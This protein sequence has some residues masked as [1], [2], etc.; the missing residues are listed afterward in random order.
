MNS[1]MNSI[2]RDSM[3]S[4]QNLDLPAHRDPFSSPHRRSPVP[5]DD[6]HLAELER[7]NARLQRLVAELLIKNQQLRACADPGSAAD[8]D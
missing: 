3:S 4:S 8:F 7:E 6:L 1:V 5:S 2:E